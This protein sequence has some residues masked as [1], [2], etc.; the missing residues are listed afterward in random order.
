MSAEPVAAGDEYEVVRRG[1]LGQT[2]HH[3][4]REAVAKVTP[5]RA[6]FANGTWFALDDPKREVKP[7]YLD[8]V[9]TAE[10]VTK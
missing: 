1:H 4:R 9:T 2:V 10:E 6:Y 5:K 3:R 8:Y 7:P